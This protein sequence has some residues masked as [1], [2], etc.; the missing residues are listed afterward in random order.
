MAR[1]KRNGVR[2]GPADLYRVVE[3]L[4]EVKEALVV[5]VERGDGY[6]MP[7]FVHLADGALPEATVQVIRQ[8]I[9][10]ALSQSGTSA[11]AIS[12][13]GLSGQM[14]GAVLLDEG[15]VVLRPSIIWCDTNNEA[16]SLSARIP[17]AIEVRAALYTC[18]HSR[19]ILWWDGAGLQAR[20]VW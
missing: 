10:A 3:A 15:G 14:H 13:V 5:G 18:S 16:D 9:R 11:D 7:L 19:Y 1:A 12:C 6:Y 4:D 2:L 20:R 17:D 8:A